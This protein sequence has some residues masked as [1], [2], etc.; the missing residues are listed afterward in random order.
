MFC[1]GQ[2]GQAVSF[3]TGQFGYSIHGIRL[4]ASSLCQ[5]SPCTK[6]PV[7]FSPDTQPLGSPEELL[8]SIG[9]GAQDSAY[10]CLSWTLGWTQG[11]MGMQVAEQEGNHVEVTVPTNSADSRSRVKRSYYE[12]CVLLIHPLFCDMPSCL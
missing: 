4:R 9:R 11:R 10:R 7:A 2:C 3:P 6:T 1:R 5:G 12:V 8:P